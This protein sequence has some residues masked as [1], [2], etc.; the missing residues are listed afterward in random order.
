MKKFIEYQIEDI[1]IELER[2]SNDEN[3]KNSLT[4]KEL[5]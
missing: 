4:K 2:S 1:D 3:I 5:Y